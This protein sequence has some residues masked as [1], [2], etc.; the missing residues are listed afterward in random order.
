MRRGLCPPG[1]QGG[2]RAGLITFYRYPEQGLQEPRRSGSSCSRGHQA[3]RPRPGKGGDRQ[4]AAS[5]DMS[6]AV[7]AV[8][9]F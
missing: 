1:G 9:S 3:Q 6:A 8:S 5:L 2:R 4:C 7:I